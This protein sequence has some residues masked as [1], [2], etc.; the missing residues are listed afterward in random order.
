MMLVRC[1]CAF[2]HPD[3][4]KLVAQTV[5]IS[6]SAPGYLACGARIEPIV[7]IGNEHLPLA[8][9]LEIVAVWP[10]EEHVI[11]VEVFI[12]RSIGIGRVVGQRG[13]LTHPVL[14]G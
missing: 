12:T 6:V 10:P 14:A 9:N 5:R 1:E 2:H 7:V 4:M 8:Q 3:S 13:S 11:F